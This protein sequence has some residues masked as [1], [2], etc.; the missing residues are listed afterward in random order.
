MVGRLQGEALGQPVVIEGVGAGLQ[1]TIASLRSAWKMRRSASPAL[2]PLLRLFQVFGLGVRVQVAS[3]PAI[4]ILPQPSALLAVVA[5][6]LR[7]PPDA[8]GLS[9]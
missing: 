9:S 2:Q 4:E 7:L 5:P 8:S 3:L 6:S 1:V